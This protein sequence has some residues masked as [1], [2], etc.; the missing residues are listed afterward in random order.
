MS[1]PKVT[2]REVRNEYRVTILDFQRQRIVWE[3]PGSNENYIRDV[4]K[5]INDIS[6]DFAPQFEHRTV[7]FIEYEWRDITP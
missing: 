5:R 4:W 7:E 2:H 3:G 6:P 1:L